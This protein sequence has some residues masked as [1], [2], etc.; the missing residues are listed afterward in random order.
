MQDDTPLQVIGESARTQQ[1]LQNSLSIALHHAS[2]YKTIEINCFTVPKRKEGGRMFMAIDFEQPEAYS[3]IMSDDSL[4]T[5]D[6]LEAGLK[7]SKH[8]C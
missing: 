5:F 7:S 2:S 8:V 4:T 6:E 3:E 1:I